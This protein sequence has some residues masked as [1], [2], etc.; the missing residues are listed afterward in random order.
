MDSRVRN[1]QV[2]TPA[3]TVK[4]LRHRAEVPLLVAASVLTI[5]GLIGVILALA[6]GTE[7][8]DTGKAILLG[9]A[10]PVLAFVFIRYLY[11]QKAVN[12]VEIT[13]H[14]LPEVY[15]IYRK[16]GAEMGISPLPRLYLANGNGALNAF[17]AKCRVRHNYIMIWSDLLDI[18]YEH[19]DFDGVRFVLAHE[20]GHVKCRHT[21]LW[22]LAILAVPRLLLLG[23]T[24]TRAQEYSA[25]RCAAYYA[26]EGAHSMLVLFAGKR[27]YRHCSLDA[28]RQS[29]DNHKDGFWLKFSNFMADHPVGWRRI[30][31]LADIKTK[32]WD[33]HGKML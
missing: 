15:E 32:G 5:V 19:G 31:P 11:W 25:D 13:E 6:T 9:I 12:S 4:Q 7:L 1:P 27:M 28:F 8:T 21:D 17:A 30:E 2:A 22:R 3:P 29:V 20:L 23:R 26:P 14:Q 18:A 16:T 24:V 10:T 33:Q